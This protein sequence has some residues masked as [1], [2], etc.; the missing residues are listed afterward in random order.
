[1]VI[2]TEYWTAVGIRIA[3]TYAKN[4]GTSIDTYCPKEH[5]GGTSIDTYLQ[6]QNVS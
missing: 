6:K 4:G 1:M 2:E 5:N 3:L